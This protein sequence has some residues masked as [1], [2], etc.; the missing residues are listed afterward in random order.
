V[1]KKAQG[2]YLEVCVDGPVRDGHEVWG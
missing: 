2:G 1:V